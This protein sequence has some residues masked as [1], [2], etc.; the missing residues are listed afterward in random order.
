[1]IFGA[2]QWAR[3]TDSGCGMKLKNGIDLPISGTPEQKIFAPPPVTRYALRG[4]RDFIGLKPS[5]RVS[6]GD[7]VKMGQ[8]L[9]VN[10]DNADV[11][12]PA[13][14]S[15]E[16][17]AVER[18]KRR[19]LESVVIQSDG[20]DVPYRQSKKITSRASAQDILNF[21]L[22]SGHFTAFK[23]RPYSKVPSPK[24][25]P[26]AIFI[27]AMDTNPLAVDA[28]VVLREKIRYFQAG[29]EGIAKLTKGPT[30]VCVG[31][32]TP[33]PTFKNKNSIKTQI[34]EG[35]HPAGNVGTHIHFLSPV[36]A[37]K[38]VWAIGY[39]DVINIGE[40]FLDGR[41]SFDR[42]VA[43]AGPCVAQPRLIR[44]RMGASLKQLVGSEVTESMR[45][46]N[47]S[48]LSGDG[49]TNSTAFLGRVATQISVIAAKTDS[50]TLG[51]LVPWRDKFS[52]ILNVHL[53]SFLRS[54]PQAMDSGLNGSYRAIISV[55]HL[56]KLTPLDILPTQL[57]RSIMV[58]D[59]IMANKL[60]VLELD[61]EDVALF[62]YADIG[63]ND[64]LAAFRECLTK[65][66]KEG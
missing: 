10:R 40:W 24:V 33:L 27:T 13:P 23:T 3:I 20:I 54:R 50:R 55:G 18:G 35:R 21:L 42:V 46:I 56:E 58:G 30:F 14:T 44:T 5:M 9:F 1:M 4:V 57:M 62:S 60:G 6:V 45:I 16:V 37:T 7:L 8:P 32:G 25:P 12:Y 64:F 48:V 26:E 61:E 43:F 39:Q 36:S 51:W 2:L 31:L 52:S 38:M 66:E 15:G 34:F 11:I 53:S 29:V 22:N 47:G 19:A 49:V 17:V 28:R 41:Y 63:K 59:T 65:I